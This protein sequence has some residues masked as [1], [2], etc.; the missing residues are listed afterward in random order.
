MFFLVL[1]YNQVGKKKFC[2]DNISKLLIFSSHFFSNFSP[3]DL[4]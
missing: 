4:F 3:G 2:Q 1:V